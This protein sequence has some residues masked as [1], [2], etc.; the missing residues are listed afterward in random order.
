[1]TDNERGDGS[2]SYERN[3]LS[4]NKGFG[5]HAFGISGSRPGYQYTAD[6][7]LDSGAD[8]YICAKAY[9]YI[10]GADDR[11]QLDTYQYS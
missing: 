2:K 8:T 7:N 6:C 10:P 1:M 5:T 3:S 4:Y 9:Q 11:R